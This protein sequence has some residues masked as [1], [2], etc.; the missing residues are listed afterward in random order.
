MKRALSTG[1]ILLAGGLLLAGCR[2][3]RQRLADMRVDLQEREERLYARYG[4]SGTAR[5]AAEAAGKV[6][7]GLGEALATGA[8]ETDRKVFWLACR[9]AGGA[10]NGPVVGDAE[11]FLAAPENRKAC[12][13]IVRLEQ[14]VRLLEAEVQRQ[15]AEA[16][17]QK[18]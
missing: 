11:T 6:P 18:K 7:G 16:Q 15:D 8:R 17:Q 5:A 13:D 9:S 1:F 3:P 14:D 2:T 4:G 12:A 10:F